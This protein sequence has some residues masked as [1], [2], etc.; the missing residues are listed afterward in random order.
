MKLLMNGT[1]SME[2]AY[3]YGKYILS[4]NRRLRLSVEVVQ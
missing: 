3:Y 1:G 2:V 4:S